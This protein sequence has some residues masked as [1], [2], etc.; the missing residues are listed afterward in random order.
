MNKGLKNYTKQISLTVGNAAE[1]SINVNKED[2]NLHISLPLITTVGLC[3]IE[4]SLTFN[5]QDKNEVDLF[6]KGFKLNFF[7]KIT[8]TKNVINVKNNDGSNDEYTTS[9]HYKN[10]ETGLEVKRVSDG[11]YDFYHYE[12]KD[13]YNNVS[14]FEKNRNYPRMVTFKNGDKL[15]LDFVAST[16]YIKNNKGDEVRFTKNGTDNIEKVEYYH[17]N[18][19]VNSVYIT[20]DSNGNISKL[21]YKNGSTIVATT[22]LTFTDNYIIVIDDL[23]GYRIKY[24]LSN[25]FVVSFIDGFDSNFTNGH[26]SSIEYQ[27]VYS[28]LT[29]YKGEKVYTFFENDNL[30]SY[31]LDEKGNIIE[32]EFDSETKSLKSNSGFI[33]FNSLENLF[34]LTD[35]SNFANEGLTVTKISQ[36]DDKFK[37]I[38]DENV[39]KVSGTG[40]LSKS[41]SINGLASDNTL[42]VLF[43]KQLTPATAD[44]YVE[45]TLSAGGTDTD[46]FNKKNV[47][48][49]FELITL[50]TSTESSFDK[51]TLTIKLVGNAEIE[52]GGIKVS[53]KEFASFYNYDESG[54]AT[55][56]GSGN[57]FTNLTYG[58]SNL[59]SQS[60]GADSTLFN[61]E[62]DDYGNLIKA[63]TAYGAKIENTYHSTYKSNLIL[64]KVTNK[65]ETKILET[66][67]TYT[68]DGR[69]VATSTDELGNVTTYNEYDALGK[70][71]KVTNALG[72]VSKF[73]YNGDGTL[74]KIILESGTSSINAAYTYDSKKRLS[75]ITLSNNSIYN[76]SY[77]SLNNIKEIKLNGVLVFSYEY[78]LTTGNLVKLK[79]GSNGETYIFEYNE[80]SLVS[81][82]YYE[83]LTTNKT[84][85][86]K[87]IYNEDKQLSKVEDGRGNVLNEY[88]YDDNNRVKSIKTSNSEIKNSYD[89]LGNVATKAITI[90]SKKYYSSFDSVSR[91]KGSHPG[92]IYQPFNQIDAYI[93]AFEKDGTIIC[94]NRNE[95]L[96]PIINHTSVNENLETKLDGI[97]PYIEVNSQN[98]LSYQLSDEFR[99]F[100]HSPCGCIGFWF[101]PNSNASSNKQYLFSTHDYNSND[102]NFIGVYLQDNY[103]HVEVVDY[104]GTTYDLIKSTYKIQ[105]DKWNFFVLNYISRC[106]GPN[107]PDIC[108]YDL[109]LNAHQQTYKKQNPRLYVDCGFKS[110]MNIGHK[111]VGENLSSDDFNGKITCLIFG[112]GRYLFNSTILQFYRLTKDYIIDNQL[113]DGTA[114]TVDFSQTNLFTINQNILNMFDIYPLQNNVV[115]LNDKRPIKFNMRKLSN[116]DKDRTFNFNKD[117]KRYAYVAD[118]EDLVYDFDISNTGTI[119]MRAYTDVTND[120]QYFIDGIDENNKSIG[121]FRR[122][123]DY[124]YLK[125]GG[126]LR[127]TGL[128][129][130]NDSWHTIVLSFK[131]T[132]SSSSQGSTR[133]IDFRVMVDDDTWASTISTNFSYGNIKFLIGKN[134]Y[135]TEVDS[136]FG[137]Y[138]T[139]YPLWGQ[140]EMIATRPAYCELSTLNTLINEL[141]GLTKVSEF[142]ELGMLKKVEIHECGKSILSNT[143]DYKKRSSNTKYI[144]KQV[145]QETI[146]FG[147]S[148][149]I[150]KY[151]TDALG[152]I[153]KITDNLFG[154]HTYKYDYRGFLIEADNE[155]Y[156]YDN[157]GNIT[158][159]GNLTA[160][161][162]TTIK[163]RIVSFNGK[164]I[165]Y[166]SINPLNPKSYGSNSYK[167]EGR[168]LVR[169][170]YG[171]GY[172]EYVYNDQGLRIQKKDYRGVTWNYTYDGDRLIRETSNNATLDFLYDENG[173]LYGFIKD[174]TDKYFYIRDAFQNILGIVDVLGNIVV[175]YSYNA[176]GT[177]INTQDT[178]SSNIGSLNPFRYKG[179]YYDGESG[180][181][182]CNSRYYSPELCRFISPDSIEFLDPQS[183]NGLN[184]YCYCMNN[185][186]MY[187]DPSGHIPEWLSTTLKIIGGIAII[188]GCVVGSI[189]TGG[190][191]SV[192]LAGAAI[193]ATA[194]GIGAGIST[195]V[196]GG[197][198]HDFANAILMSTATGAISGA[199]AASP[200]GVG[201]QIGINAALGAA[202][203]AGT[204][205]LSGGN[206]TLGGLIVNAG[207]GALCGWI[208]QS[209]WMQGLTTSVFVAFAGKN[210]LKHVVSMVGTETL[211]RM[212]LPAFV[213]GGVGGGIYGRLSAQ[214]N[215]NG[216]F[217]GI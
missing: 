216:N 156:E 187:A 71:K 109:F 56:M 203:Y 131:E 191:L 102:K 110:P 158:K 37:C 190:A 140:I 124:I 101:K 81:N 123:N 162:D 197:D 134:H 2:A 38:L 211:L 194:G 41:I 19:L 121:L 142:D 94:Q 35:I 154:N 20:Y 212:T 209:G 122:S 201:A 28:V 14:E 177:T 174:N 129:F 47:D 200:L 165:E 31:E 112:R 4:T 78:D 146:K 66:K 18:S 6:G 176:W 104:N 58:S 170:T 181:F 44:S 64:N 127:N 73:T 80:D 184:L 126:S 147:S 59:P 1:T 204:Q 75:K 214:F 115:S 45:V 199:V 93:G 150:R 83:S 178:S 133:N 29:N 103:V 182:Y 149:Y 40:T 34:D 171:G 27:N 157:N 61:Y 89:N 113:V 46:K 43:G 166:D 99:T 30:P 49:Q 95:G 172:Y 164:D 22:S 15:T 159:K 17:N 21:T 25:N 183:I 48:N 151:E 63:E 87:Y 119:V 208:G 32:T 173:N 67:K 141:K 85:K 92:S 210:A 217:I 179:Y 138:T 169:W 42:A 135:E 148:S 76:F 117:I 53:K 51:I 7:K 69:F 118:G 213:L 9:N 215:P 105:T 106:D 175:K 160:T 144:S 108:E 207:I 8:S 12:I 84:L 57:K 11:D 74:N 136:S 68:S 79:Y 50:G 54:N 193:G 55:Q 39:Y 91:S 90:D 185:P 36:N 60:I 96:Y 206:I 161:Y 97:I 198:I 125:I 116:L 86:F 70:I 114:K 139:H 153:T 65:D 163:D 132:I 33:S 205:L 143:Y 5:L 202:N 196:S 107:S 180:L 128:K 98:R 167:F 192:V 72:A 52:I 195:A 62:Y 88:T 168:R 111:F 13:K 26:Q 16:K 188:A 23:S 152:N 10:K 82:I 130:S 189:F 24:N 155:T 100:F 120:I 3:P 137:S 77:D 145:S 186:I